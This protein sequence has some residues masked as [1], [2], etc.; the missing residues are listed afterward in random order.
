[1]EDQVAAGRKLVQF[2]ANRFPYP[3]PDPVSDDGI[4]QPPR[5]G[6]ANSGQRE[7]GIRR[8]NHHE[9]RTADLLAMIVD[10][11]K[12]GRFQQQCGF[13]KGVAVAGRNWTSACRI[14]RFVR[15]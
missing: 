7:S 9:K 10:P 12:H 6:E 5:N 13:R 11:L 4:T 3:A 1:M 14:E 8:A 15:R 2:Q